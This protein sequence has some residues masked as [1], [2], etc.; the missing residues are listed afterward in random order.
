MHAR[1]RT[2]DSVFSG[3]GREGMALVSALAM[4]LLF[5]LLGSA[6][7]RS[8][9]IEFDAAN[10]ATQETRARFL[11]RGGI[12][13]AVGALET[14]LQSG[15]SLD[16]RTY[17]LALPLYPN[18]QGER[19]AEVQEV[20]VHLSDESGR[21]NVNH[22]SIQVLEAIGI[23]RAAAAAIRN[24]LPRADLPSSEERQWL[25]SVDG[26]LARGFLGGRAFAGLNRE[27]LTVYTVADP[28]SPAGYI[29]INTASPAVLAAL[30]NIS[31]AEA[32]TLADAR[33]FT[34]WQDAVDKTGR[35]PT[36][37]NVGRMQAVPGSM[38]PSLSLTSRCYRIVCEAW[39]SGSGARPS[40]V[41][42]EAVVLFDENGGHRFRYWEASRAKRGENADDASGAGQTESEARLGNSGIQLGRG[43]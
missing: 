9:R 12:N 13:A 39:A 16:G 18:R 27:A 21:I 41:R 14:A 34:S 22:S 25:A 31:S 17:T 11:A 32:Q 2:T 7:V 38:P 24:G 23:D 28:F 4:L 42:V 8:M 36:T 43:A 37:Y 33:P 3:C 26:L 10:I 5:S 19:V 40:G 15:E 6:Y 35:D 30:F 29:N 20:T 1:I